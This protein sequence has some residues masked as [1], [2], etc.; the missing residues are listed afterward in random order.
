MLRVQARL[1][2]P[3]LIKG[4][5]NLVN[6]K[7]D[8]SQQYVPAAWKANSILGYIRRGVAIR[9]EVAGGG[10]DCCPLICSCEAPYGAV[11]LGLGASSTDEGHQ[12]DQMAGALLL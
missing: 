9:R 2:I 1:V 11:C 10:W 4:P 5:G 3:G 8:V 12:D 6:K 7:L